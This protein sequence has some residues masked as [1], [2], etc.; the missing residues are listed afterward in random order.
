MGTELNTAKTGYF[1]VADKFIT[2]L[3]QVAAEPMISIFSAKISK[4]TQPHSHVVHEFIAGAKGTAVL[5][6]NGSQYVISPSQTILVPAGI[7]HHYELESHGKSADVTFVCF[8]GS[9]LGSLYRES[10][11]SGS[12]ALV[13][14][15]VTAA[16]MNKAM[17]EETVLLI[18]LLE[19]AMDEGNPHSREKAEH[20]LASVL[21]NHRACTDNGGTSDR[22]D[23]YEK[24]QEILAWINGN[25][26]D[27]LSIDSTAAR[28]HMSRS[29]FTRSFKQYTNLSFSEYVTGARLRVASDLLARGRLPIGEVAWRSG[30]R[31]IGHFYNQFQKQYGMT[32]SQYRKVSI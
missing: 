7:P 8:D 14:N 30:F 31:N 6:V 19:K 26:T 11:E 22:S 25:L 29:T 28:S 1:P 20:I 10:S 12:N 2:L 3:G 17:A 5:H 24:I 32:P 9:S 27:E 18:R 13:T 15:R 23:K 16:A 4:N 21:V